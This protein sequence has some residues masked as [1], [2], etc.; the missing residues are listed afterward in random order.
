MNA[1]GRFTTNKHFESFI[2][3]CILVN[4]V[5]LALQDPAWNNNTTP[6]WSI[7]FDWAFN[8]IFVLECLLKIGACGF[9]VGAECCAVSLSMTIYL[10][11]P[12]HME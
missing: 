5:T 2:I 3:A 6:L 9:K 7:V 10:T 8:V 12:P 1:L 4:C 11:D